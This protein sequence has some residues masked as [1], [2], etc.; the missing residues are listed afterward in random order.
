VEK[1]LIT[2]IIGLVP[3]VSLITINTDSSRRESP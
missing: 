1:T 3:P 2:K